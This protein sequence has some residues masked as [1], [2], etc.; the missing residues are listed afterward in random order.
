AA[1]GIDIDVVYVDP[2]S[3]ARWPID[4]KDLFSS[5]LYDVFI[6]H[7]LDASVFF[8]KDDPRSSLGTLV[9]Q[10]EKGKGFLMIGGNHSFGAGGYHDTPLGNILPIAMDQ[11]ERQSFS[12]GQRRSDLHVPG[13]IALRPARSHYLTKLFVT[14]NEKNWTKLPPLSSVN[15]F[16]GIKD[17]ARVLLESTDAD[18]VLIQGNF[19]GRI[20]LFAGDSTWKW[21]T[22]SNKEIHK[23]FWR[24]VILWLAKRDG[25]GNDNIWVNLPQRRIEPETD[26]RFTCEASSTLGE[27]I[28]SAQFMGELMGP[29]EEVHPVVITT[30]EGEST[31]DID[32]DL[33]RSPGKYSLSVAA[34]QDNRELGSTRI[35]F[36]VLDR[37][38]EKSNPVADPGRLLRM[39]K[40]TSHWGGRSLPPEEFGS[41]ISEII[42]KREDQEIEIEVKWQ[43]GDTWQDALAVVLGFTCLLGFEWTLRKKWGLV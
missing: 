42:E 15:R 18:P 30:F 31:G 36:V 34:T 33:L 3:R 20:L 19:G 17:Q 13:P 11:F 10:V 27:K 39:S 25:M 8:K 1:Q 41:L 9:N 24:Q 35:E 14:E 4:R 37:D 40:Q 43:L 21:W 12:F 7:D 5:A 26:V 28:K 23:R 22:S 2:S 16:K 32:S 38:S 29:D 6:F